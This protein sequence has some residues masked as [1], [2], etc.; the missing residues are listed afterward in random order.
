MMCV[1]AKLNF[2]LGV[3]CKEGLCSGT[4]MTMV[5]SFFVFIVPID[6]EEKEYVV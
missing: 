3:I 2:T 4:I 6:V 5:L 1:F